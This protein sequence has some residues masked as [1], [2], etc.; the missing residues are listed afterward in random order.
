VGALRT[1][2]LPNPLEFLC[3]SLSL[4]TIPAGASLQGKWRLCP[5]VATMLVTLGAVAFHEADPAVLGERSHS[6]QANLTRQ[7]RTKRG[8]DANTVGPSALGLPIINVGLPKSA[9]TSVLDF[10]KCNGLKASHYHC[11]NDCS[12]PGTSR[13]HFCQDE[14]KRDYCGPCIKSN[15]KHGAAPFENCGDYD[16]RSHVSNHQPPG[17]FL[18]C[19]TL[20]LAFHR[21][22][23]RWTGHGMAQT[24]HAFFRR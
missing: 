24:S 19:L 22:G 14:D 5:E 11:Q 21:S 12:K 1:W 3:V 18:A 4:Q 8:H 17:C 7:N 13:K 9:S 2:P 15:F 20:R 10:F 16:V 23:R 6:V